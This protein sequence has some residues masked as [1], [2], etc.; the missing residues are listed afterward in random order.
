MLGLVPGA[1]AQAF[2]PLLTV[3]LSPSEEPIVHGQFT[4]IL[5]TVTL[6]TE[7]ANAATRTNGI[8]VTYGLTEFPS[9]VT[10]TITPSADIFV[11]PTSAGLTSSATRSFVLT[12]S[13]TADAPEGT[14]AALEVMAMSAPDL[15][16][17]PAP[18]RGAVAIQASGD[19]CDQAESKA[20]NVAV[21]QSAPDAGI[22]EEADDAQQDDADTTQRVQSAGSVPIAVPWTV[23]VL[24]CAIAG[25]AGGVYLRR[26]FR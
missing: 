13:A 11:F 16:M 7:S 5:G 23:A 26:R 18:G 15:L 2:K 25:T 4:Q 14:V 20:P 3:N 9:W 21:V 1:E 10:V 24:G 12:V 19:P 6:V 17:S 22:D 8:L